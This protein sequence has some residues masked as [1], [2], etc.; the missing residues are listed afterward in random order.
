MIPNVFKEDK[1]SDICVVGYVT[2]VIKGKKYGYMKENVRE[3][4]MQ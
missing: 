2:K 3:N 1:A 4:M